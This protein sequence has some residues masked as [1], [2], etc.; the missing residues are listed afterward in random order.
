MVRTAYDF[1]N[2][3]GFSSVEPIS[4]SMPLSDETVVFKSNQEPDAMRRL[5]FRNYSKT[6]NIRNPHEIYPDSQQSTPATIEAIEESV[7]RDEIDWE[8]L[9]GTEDIPEDAPMPSDLEVESEELP[10]LRRHQ[11][12]VA[13]QKTRPRR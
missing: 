4:E 13:S 6:F 7:A 5:A 12:A 9:P 10:D 11:S 3:G 8:P 2:W 1:L